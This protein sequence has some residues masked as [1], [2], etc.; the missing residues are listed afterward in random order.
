MAEQAAAGLDTGSGEVAAARWL[1]AEDATT[2]QAL[3]WAM[4]HDPAVALRLAV[5]LAPWWLLRGRLTG[6]YPLLR[7]AAGRAEPGSDRWSAAQSWLGPTAFWSGDQ[8]AA[9]GHFTAVCDAIGGRPPCRALVDCLGGRSVLFSN[10][11]QP[12]E[13]ADDGRRAWPWPAGSATRLAKRWPWWASA[14]PPR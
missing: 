14:L 7:E 3:A 13:A 12:A 9:L 10:L 11:G 8:V 1:D 2:L 6:Q 5:A 4:D